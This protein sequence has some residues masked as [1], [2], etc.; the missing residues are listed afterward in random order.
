M[1]KITN[2]CS[3]GSLTIPLIYVYRNVKKMYC[4]SRKIYC[5][6]LTWGLHWCMVFQPWAF[7][8]MEGS[9]CSH[10]L[11]DLFLRRPC[12]DCI[13]DLVS[14]VLSTNP[15]E[16]ALTH[17]SIITNLAWEYGRAEGTTIFILA[18]FAKT[19]SSVMPMWGDVTDK[20][21][22]LSANF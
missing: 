16:V 19:Q 22:G 6:K 4:S 17:Q 21:S 20:F 3:V 15:G 7:Y 2:T 14:L 1:L 11:L 10:V 8:E 13:C 5:L 12:G 9:W 18:L